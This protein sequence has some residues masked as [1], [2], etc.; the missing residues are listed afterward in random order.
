MISTNA[1]DRDQ[2]AA[3]ADEELITTAIGWM[4]FLRAPH[5]PIAAWEND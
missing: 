1:T 4:A 3:P 2:D 5:I